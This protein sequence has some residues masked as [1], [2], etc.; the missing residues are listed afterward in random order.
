ML[1]FVV[2]AAA[3]GLALS[4]RMAASQTA[5]DRIAA[6]ILDL[7]IPHKESPF[8]IVTASFGIATVRP[9]DGGN[10]DRLIQL[11]D[12]ALYA[13]KQGG[14]NRIETKCEAEYVSRA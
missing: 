14:R 1:R 10:P 12:N 9:R 4:A 2:P 6:A 3:I 11:A 7:K 5:A 8:R 13:A